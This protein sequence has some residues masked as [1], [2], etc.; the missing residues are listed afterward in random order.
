MSDYICLSEKIQIY[1]YALYLKRNNEEFAFPSP[2]PIGVPII[3][4]ERR[5]YVQFACLPGGQ[6]H[7]V[8][9]VLIGVALGKKSDDTGR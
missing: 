3:S 8:A 7:C 9:W 4:H 2:F 1:V 5:T 6:A